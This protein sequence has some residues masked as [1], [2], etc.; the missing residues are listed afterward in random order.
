[1]PHLLH[2]SSPT[3][4]ILRPP[5]SVLFCS[6]QTL[7][8]VPHTTVCRDSSVGTTI[9]YGA[10]SPG[11]E[12]RWGGRD[13]SVPVQT[14]PGAHPPSYTM[15]TGRRGVNHPLLSSVEVKERVDLNL[16][17]PFRP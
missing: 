9:R 12:S 8:L 5:T 14:G 6:T 16:C 7:Y 3:D 2:V 4:E 11:I 17:S 15:S 13:F 10:D 1:M